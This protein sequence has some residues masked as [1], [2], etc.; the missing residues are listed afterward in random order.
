MIDSEFVIKAALEQLYPVSG[1]P[2]WEAIM[3]ASGSLPQ[4]RRRKWEF[5]LALVATAI[6]AVALTT[7][8]GAAIAR[9]LGGFSTWI[10]GEPGKPAPSADQRQF[11]QA[12][13]RSW[14]GF[15][16]G[17]DLRELLTTR[18]AGTTVTL[19][20]FR[21]G[22]TTFCL[23][24]KI[25]G[26]AGSVRCAPVADLKRS[27]APARVLIADQPVGKGTKTAWY[28]IWRLHSSHLQITAGIA[29]D[30]VRQIVLQDDQGRH[31]VPVRSNAFVYVAVDPEVGQR[32]SSVTAIT[33][34]GRV[35]IPFVSK[36][37]GTGGGASAAS[38]PAVAVTAPLRDGH[39]SWLERHDPRGERLGVLPARIR[40]GLLGYHGLGPRSQVLFG[41][42]LSP[43]PSR[44]LRIVVTLNA[45]H[46]GGP[47]AGICVYG[48]TAGG[49]GGGCAPY[50]DTFAH[51]PFDFT[52]SGGGSATF[53]EVTGVA[54]DGVARIS[55]ILA[56]RQSLPIP[57]RD[58]AFVGEIPT[59]RL[60]A[61]LVAY[62]AK[63]QVVGTSDSVDG[64][65]P[66]GPSQTRGKAEQLMAVKGAHGAHAELLV[67]RATGSGEC[68][69]FKTYFSKR[70]AGV[71]VSCRA[72]SWHGSPLQFG[73]ETDFFLG[74][75]RPDIKRVRIDY[76]GGGSSTFTL[77]R[78]YLLARIP[79]AHLTRASPPTRFIGLNAEGK[80]VANQAIPAPPPVPRRR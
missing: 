50:P 65:A 34:R 15:P 31:K 80:V 7:P 67:G 39:I 42:V 29:A 28:G 63:G 4:P 35:S 78:G 44:P 75:A 62:N 76:L 47:A 77:V 56:N 33:A 9:G 52:T 25:S 46:H 66:G 6:V 73:T 69:Y 40:K 14:I 55:A 1:E 59:A 24:L 36:L 58:N 11:D 20:G 57:L 5:A 68:A 60:P 13:Q 10:S 17:T 32:V 74:R 8:L 61:R 16:T 27:D 53:V 45:H 72:A 18:A 43:D 70:A 23:K 48:A 71:M 37:F 30:L 51:S 21:S 49:G 2:D 19:Y 79:D 26:A 38:P 12:N 22:N 64:F 3:A 41:R 54:A